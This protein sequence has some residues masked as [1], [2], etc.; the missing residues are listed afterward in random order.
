MLNIHWILVNFTEKVLFWFCL[1]LELFKMRLRAAICARRIPTF[2]QFHISGQIRLD[3]YTAQHADLHTERFP[4]SKGI[5]HCNQR[6]IAFSWSCWRSGENSLVI[7]KRVENL[8][9]IRGKVYR[10]T[11]VA[12]SPKERVHIFVKLPDKHGLGKTHLL[13]LSGQTSLG[14][15]GG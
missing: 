7:R 2:A 14:R 3:D 9:G 10:P 4:N 13:I 11:Y 15:L 12:W 1:M 5:I 6:W 8:G